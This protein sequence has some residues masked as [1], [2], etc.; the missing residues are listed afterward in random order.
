MIGC[1][2]SG[3][4]GSP[5]ENIDSTLYVRSKDRTIVT[6]SFDV[7]GGLRCNRSKPT[8]SNE[9]PQLHRLVDDA[10]PSG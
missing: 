7:I 5:W 8:R 1:H 3:F 2:P 9:G 6:A 4:Q 10:L